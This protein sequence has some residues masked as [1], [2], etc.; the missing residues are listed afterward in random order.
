MEVSNS[1]IYEL[2]GQ[3]KAYEN[4]INI[5]ISHI[6]GEK[7]N[8]ATIFAKQVISIKDLEKDSKKDYEKENDKCYEKENDKCYEK[9]NEI[10]KDIK[11]KIKSKSKKSESTRIRAKRSRKKS[12]D[13]DE[14]ENKIKEKKLQRINNI[15]N[16][17][18][19]D[20]DSMLEIGNNNI[21]GR[22]NVSFLVKNKY[23]LLRYYSSQKYYKIITDFYKI[24]GNKILD[25]FDKNWFIGTNF[26]G[27]VDND[28]IDVYKLGFELSFENLENENI[29]YL[30]CENFKFPVIF[31]FNIKDIFKTFDILLEKYFLYIN[32]DFYILEKIND[33]I[34]HYLKDTSL[35]CF[36]GILS[37]TIIDFM[38]ESFVKLYIHIYSHNCI[39]EMFILETSENSIEFRQIIKNLYILTNDEF[40][41][42]LKSTIKG[43]CQRELKQNEKLFNEDND[44]YFDNEYTFDYV[45]TQLFSN[46]K[47]DIHY[48][49]IQKII[50]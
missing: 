10:I 19:E 34:Y 37:S 32:D 15:F 17:K 46:Y 8:L 6:K 23:K 36:I 13:I 12:N 5:L 47:K 16:L 22:K 27:I 2:K 42:F 26:S 21:K 18:Q 44:Q 29:N 38:I 35:N 20:I 14:I 41:I 31:Y 3:I 33:N 50:N 25:E 28:L 48:S 39:N 43:K 9:E 7:E 1:H 49:I 11:S 24:N 45:L 30:F 40:K 4:I